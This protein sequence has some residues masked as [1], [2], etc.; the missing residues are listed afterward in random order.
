MADADDEWDDEDEKMVFALT[1]DPRAREFVKSMGRRMQHEMKQ[2]NW[3]DDVRKMEQAPTEEG[4]GSAI[5]EIYS[6]TRVNG[7]A[8][9]AGIVPGLS[10][11]LT[12]CDPED[13]LPW[14]LNGPNRRK[15]ALDK[16]LGKEALLLVGSPMCKAFS[17]LQNMSKHKRAREDI[18]KDMKERAK[19]IFNSAVCFTRFNGIRV[20]TFSMSIHIPPAAGKYRLSNKSHYWRE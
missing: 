17:R 1:D 14:D 16:V 5:I 12:T 20:D 9:R 4:I 15:K 11:H 18:Q 8:A 10:L 3:E 7:M 2:P 13:G 6:P 19:S